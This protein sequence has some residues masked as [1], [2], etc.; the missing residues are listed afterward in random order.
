MNRVFVTGTGRVS[1]SMDGSGLTPDAA[2]GG[3]LSGRVA[4][5]VEGDEP[6]LHA[7]ARVAAGKAVAQARRLG[8][9][10]PER[11]GVFVSAS[12]GGLEGFPDVGPSLWRYLSDSPGGRL[13]QRLGWTGGGSNTPLACA[14]GAYS[15]G[16]AFES[17]RSGRLQA[18]LAGAAEASLTPLVAAAFGNLGA[19]SGPKY[20]GPFDE[21]RAGFVL[22]EGAGVLLLESEE[23]LAVTGH[24]PLAELQAWA[25]TS[26]AYHLTAPEPEG[27]EAARCLRLAL[28]KAGDPAVAYVNAHGTATPTGDLAEAKAMHS[29][30]GS[31]GGPRISSIKG[32][33]GH[34]LGAAGALEAAVTV[35]ALNERRLPGTRRCRRP[36][37]ELKAR[38]ALE[39]E[40]LDGDVAVSLS[41]GFGGHNV[42]LVFKRVA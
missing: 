31:S 28:A 29:V 42:A 22:A 9:L 5:T 19:L 7:L 16:L 15:M 39:D 10:Q 33:I 14:T 24:R 17:L 23:G 26:D 1:P 13:R 32:A 38:L 37:A 25:C 35:D 34:A 12:K 2:L 20:A 8:R 27:R 21:E 36:M 41:M 4:V 11:K 40:A 6:R 30:F 3:R 18:A